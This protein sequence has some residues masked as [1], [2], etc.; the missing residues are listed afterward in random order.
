MSERGVRFGCCS[1][2]DA[3]EMVAEAGYDYI[4]PGVAST[5]RPLE[6]PE[7]FEEARR[8]VAQAPIK[9]EVFNLF[10]PGSL[11]IVGPEVDFEALRRYVKTACERVSAL[12]GRIIVFGSG[13]AR[14]RPDDFPE[15]EAR[16]QLERFCRAAA[17]AAQAAGVQIAI[18]PLRRAETNTLNTVA[19]ALEVASAVKHP[20]LQVLADLYHMAAEQEGFEVLSRADGRLIHVHLAEPPER[21][22][23][24]VRGYDFRPFFRAL[25]E[26]G[27]RGRISVE[28]RWGDFENEL[29][30]ALEVL[31]R[32]WDEVSG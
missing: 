16:S 14:R 7:R 24:G 11:K 23:P 32:Q 21:T 29:T 22:A 28:C 17:E 6:G 31:R 30:R 19:E 15:E 10:V 18:E 4:E 1:G 13:G 25:R 27:Y 26:A 12:G 20:G 8:L 3:L 2:L 5:V 9:P